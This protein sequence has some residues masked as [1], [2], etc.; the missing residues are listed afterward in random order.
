MRRIAWVLL[1]AFAFV[2]PW[3]YSLDTGEPSGNVARIL[4]LLLILV[5]IPAVFHAGRLHTP[6]PMQW[7]VLAFYLWFCCSYFWTI[8]T[9]ATLDRMRGYF[10]EMMVVWLVWEFAESPRDLR[11]LLRA[12]VAGSWV[13]AL[14]TLVNFASMDAMIAGQIRFVAQGQDPN[15]AARFLDLGFPL[16]AVLFDGE[17]RWLGRLLALGY[18]PLGLLA[19]L[20]TASRGGF[21]TAVAALLGCGILLACGHGRRAVAGAFA[22][23]AIAAALWLIVPRDTIARLATISEQAQGGNLNDRVNIWTLG[24]HAFAQAPLLG[25]GAGTY[26]TAAG[27]APIDTAHNTALSIL[28]N[29]GL[30]AFFLAVAIVA[31]AAGSIG[32]T[33]G[34]LRLALATTLLIWA[35]ASLAATVEESRTTWLLLALIALAGRLAGEDPEGLAAHFSDVRP[36]PQLAMARWW[37]ESA[38][39]CLR[40]EVG[41]PTGADQSCPRVSQEMETRRRRWDAEDRELLAAAESRIGDAG[42]ES[43]PQFSERLVSGQFPG[44]AQAQAGKQSAALVLG[45][46]VIVAVGVSMRS[47]RAQR[48]V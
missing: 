45:A 40:L 42:S 34:P 3:E 44:R 33:R 48:E 30:C 17:H 47:R 28:V 5:A 1:L 41:I 46:L 12:Y 35:I 22:L 32:K 37:P 38:L 9:S 4:G 39:T 15:D 20:L 31:L 18:L 29:G 10:Q 23:S 27:L 13:L 7:V 11:S 8:S 6:G 21:L 26:V 24:W 25:Y 16:A 19:V 2:I 14:L 36:S 43:S